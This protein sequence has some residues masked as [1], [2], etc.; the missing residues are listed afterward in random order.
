MVD[1]QTSLL[2]PHQ[3]ITFNKAAGANRATDTGNRNDLINTLKEQQQQ[4]AASYGYIIEM[5]ERN[6]DKIGNQTIPS[7]I[8][9][10]SLDVYLRI[11]RKQSGLNIFTSL[12]KK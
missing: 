9:V 2:V 1:A 6:F 8:V 4:G 5:S 10:P 12:Y 3:R 7:Q 11:T